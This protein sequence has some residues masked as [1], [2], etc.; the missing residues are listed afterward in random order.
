[1]LCFIGADGYAAIHES[2]E[3]AVRIK[4]S[5]LM[6]NGALIAP[7]LGPLGGAAW[8]HVTPWEGLFILFD[9]LAAIAFFGLQGATPVL[10][11]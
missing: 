6:A 3:A 8:V 9:A 2:F 11:T 10:T 7:L 5:A 1:R 4:I